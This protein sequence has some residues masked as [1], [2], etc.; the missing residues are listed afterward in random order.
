[1]KIV[2]NILF[3]LLVFPFVVLI[4][5]LLEFL[6]IDLWAYIG[7]RFGSWIRLAYV[8]LC[9]GLFKY[10]AAIFSLLISRIP[11]NAKL[12]LWAIGICTI[13]VA[14][15]N[16]YNVWTVIDSFFICSV[17]TFGYLYFSFFIIGGAD[18]YYAE[19]YG[20]SIFE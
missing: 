8:I 5:R 4:F 12:S 20:E 13:V 6:S 2:R 1:M 19:Q 18:A 16:I 15:I 7:K 3:I 11:T 17:I 14:I 9:F 10:I